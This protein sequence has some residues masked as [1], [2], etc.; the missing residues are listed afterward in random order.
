MEVDLCFVMDCTGSMGSHINAAKDCILNV[1]KCMEKMKPSV[2]IRF[3]FCGYRDHCDGA[4]R[5]QTFPFTESY[6]QFEKDLSGVSPMGGGDTPEDVLGGLNV[7]VNQMSWRNEARII[8]HIGDCPSH[9]RRYKN[10]DDDYPNGDPNGLTAERVLGEMKSKNIFYFFGKITSF[11]NEMVNIFRS[12]IGEFPVYDLNSV[13]TGL[14]VYK[15]FEATCSAIK[16][17]ISLIE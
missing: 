14:L 5:L 7:A 10:I 4:N 17:A 9:G 8:F 11:T 3:G 12:I 15:F 1:A 13:D 2:K 6:V 16:T